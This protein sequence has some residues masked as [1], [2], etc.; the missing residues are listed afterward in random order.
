MK[1]SRLI[2]VKLLSMNVS[3]FA[4]LVAVARYVI[5]GRACSASNCTVNYS[6]TTASTILARVIPT[7]HVAIV[8]V[9]TTV[10]V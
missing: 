6:C 1:S 9:N 8:L 3:K 5:G 4:Q 7:I 2:N 10:F